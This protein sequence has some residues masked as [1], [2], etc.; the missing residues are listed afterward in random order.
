[1]ILLAFIPPVWN[2]IMAPRLARW[3]AAASP[4]ERAYLAQRGWL[5]AA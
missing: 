4:E 2:K 5:L 1:M 3:D